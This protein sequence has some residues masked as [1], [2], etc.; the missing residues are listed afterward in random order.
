MF[1]FFILMQNH[2]FYR[3]PTTHLRQNVSFA[4]KK[5]T[6]MYYLRQFSA[7]GYCEEVG[8]LVFLQKRKYASFFIIE[9]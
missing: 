5:C 7:F 3:K 9:Y 1:A 2:P 4:T 8:D 6:Q